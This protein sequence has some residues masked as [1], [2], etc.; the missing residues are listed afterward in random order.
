VARVVIDDTGTGRL[1]KIDAW[2]VARYLQLRLKDVDL[3][4][5]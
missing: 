4:V 2:L 3:A 1:D 5:I